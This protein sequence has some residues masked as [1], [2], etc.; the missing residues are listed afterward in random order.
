VG[1][2]GGTFHIDPPL[3]ITEAQFDEF[4]A[5]YRTAVDVDSGLFP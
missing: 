2:R 3:T 4:I 1:N 5:A